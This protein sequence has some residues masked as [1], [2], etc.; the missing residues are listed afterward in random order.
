MIML[1]LASLNSCCNPWIYLAFSGGLIKSSLP[2]LSQPDL[3]YKRAKGPRVK[4]RFP[5]KEIPIQTVYFRSMRRSLWER[6]CPQDRVHACRNLCPHIRHAVL[7]HSHSM[8]YPDT[9]R[10]KEV[11]SDSSRSRATNRDRLKASL[12]ERGNVSVSN[13]DIVSSFDLVQECQ[14]PPEE[15]QTV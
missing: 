14:S 1:L 12:W 9:V 11:L 8:G 15:R 5:V 10:S 3:R 6:K 2:C 13:Q 4:L 7:R